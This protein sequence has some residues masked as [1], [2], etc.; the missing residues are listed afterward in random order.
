MW[1]RFVSEYWNK[2][3]YVIKIDDDVVVNLH[4]L[5]ALI[6]AVRENPSKGVDPR[7]IIIG[8]LRKDGTVPRNRLSKW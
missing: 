3:E 1:L 8:H 5:V 4:A 7:R 2:V 6:Y